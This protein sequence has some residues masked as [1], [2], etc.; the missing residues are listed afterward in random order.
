MALYYSPFRTEY[1]AGGPSGCPFCDEAH[2]REQSLKHPDGS[3]IEN[4]HYRWIVNW[5]PKFDG[6]TMVIPKHHV[7]SLSDETD[8]SHLL[9]RSRMLAF[10]ADTVRQLFSDA[11]VEAFIQYGT[12]SEASQEHLHWHVVPARP[13]DTFRG[14]DKADEYFTID[15]EQEKVVY[16]PVQIELARERLIAR[17]QE[18][19][20]KE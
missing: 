7:E 10:A 1:S 17:V 13:A 5:F 18:T 9:A 2:M 6:H 4:E 15:P 3:P 8:E 11:G 20:Q 19:L 16:Y 14:F 12:G